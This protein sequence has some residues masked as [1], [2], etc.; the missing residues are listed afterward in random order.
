[1]DEEATGAGT[2]APPKLEH[3]GG[4]D[5]CMGVPFDLSS[6]YEEGGGIEAATDLQDGDGVGGAA[7]L[8]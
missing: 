2:G 6:A 8:G 1:M 7:S 5:V 4:D 3:F